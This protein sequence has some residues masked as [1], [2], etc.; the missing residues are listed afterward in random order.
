MASGDHLIEKVELSIDDGD[1]WIP[2]RIPE[3]RKSG[4]WC[5]WEAQ[6]RLRP[7]THKIIVRALDSANQTQPGETSNVWNFKGYMNNSWHRIRIT[8]VEDD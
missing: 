8:V 2:A 6:L 3:A 1:Q 4:A 7:G 5:F